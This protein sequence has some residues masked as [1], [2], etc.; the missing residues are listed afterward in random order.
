MEE[1]EFD[2][3]FRS[4]EIVAA[5][6]ERI[7]RQGLA[8]L[9]RGMDAVGGQLW[10]TSKWLVFRSHSMNFQVGV[11][12]WPL[13]EIISVTS[14]NTLRIVPNGMKVVLKGGAEV[15]FVVNRRRAWIDAIAQACA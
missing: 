1:R 6:G 4:T 14:V 9:W 15:R 12:V 11:C 3:V 10:L 2:M 13:D 8:N 5:P 7:L